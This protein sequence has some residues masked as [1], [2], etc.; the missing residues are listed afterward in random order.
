MDI[1]DALDEGKKKLVKKYID[2]G[3]D[4]FTTNYKGESLLRFTIYH[5]W[6]DISLDLISKGLNINHR[7][8]YGENLLMF[9][10]EAG[11]LE[12]GKLL[13]DKGVDIYEQDDSEETA[14]GHASEHRQNKF[15]NLLQDYGY[16]DLTLACCSKNLENVKDR[17]AKGYK[18]NKVDDDSFWT[19]LTAAIYNR[20]TEVA[21]YLIS[22][23]ADV[24]LKNEWDES[25][26]AL[27]KKRKLTDMVDL[28]IANG[29]DQ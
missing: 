29:A 24:N 9:A 5:K 7:N 8:N 12:I 6:N 10:A 22:L 13:I 14:F 20:S 19:P 25:P 28:L 16:G 15:M 1:F 4:I 11:N 21:K 17:I 26:I 3:N 18:I 2:E 27:A 23:G